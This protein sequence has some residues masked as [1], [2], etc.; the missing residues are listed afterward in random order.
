MDEVHFQQHGSRCR[1]WVPPET[2][3]PVFFHQ[4]TRK[5]VGYY[6]AVRLR[7]GRF[8]FRR[9]TDKFNA[10]TCWEFLKDLRAISMGADR[11]VVVI[12]DN[13]KYH[14]ARLHQDWR[15][16]EAE[17]FSLD[18]LPPYSPELNPTERVWK[19]TRRLCVHNRYFPDLSDVALAVETEF[20]NWTKPNET[21][22]RLCAIT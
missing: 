20:T 21:L 12:A 6:G 3:D 22:R 7:D 18:F 5:S 11:R 9:E 16:Q 14:H 4:P 19:L 17:R 8:C 13:A 2:Q 15:Q 10:Q 1:M